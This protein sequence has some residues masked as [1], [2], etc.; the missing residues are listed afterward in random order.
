MEWVTEM[1]REKRKEEWKDGERERFHPLFHSTNVTKMA[2]TRTGKSQKPGVSTVWSSQWQEPK[3]LVHLL[4]L[5]PGGWQGSG[6]DMGNLGQEPVWGSISL[7]ATQHQPRERLF[8]SFKHAH[9]YTFLQ[10][11]IVL[12]VET[13][14][15]AFPFQPLCKSYHTVITKFHVFGGEL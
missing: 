10:N 2:N 12:W 15:I 14:K 9:D 8:I 11:F 4:K 5:F 7:P 3:H 1:E 6:S 13:E